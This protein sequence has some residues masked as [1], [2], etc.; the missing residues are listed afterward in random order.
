[1]KTRQVLAGVVAAVVALSNAGAQTP[2]AGV[3]PP[4]D[5]VRRA[6]LV[7]STATAVARVVSNSVVF[8][9]LGLADAQLALLGKALT[10]ENVRLA[11]S[12]RNLAETV[13]AILSDRQVA[14]DLGLTEAQRAAVRQKM[15]AEL[16]RKA[17]PAEEINAMARDAAGGAMADAAVETFRQRW[18]RYDTDGDGQVSQAERETA[19]RD[20]RGMWDERMKQYDKDGDGKLSDAERQ[21]ARDAWRTRRE[22][23]DG[24]GPAPR[25]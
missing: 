10:A 23:R 17:F 15:T 22:R 2:A 25:Q 20:M 12:A 19:F 6:P 5:P 24:G 14:A 1:M 4:G 21:A 13:A 7:E 9:E 16:I 18:Q 3:R 11:L 8:A